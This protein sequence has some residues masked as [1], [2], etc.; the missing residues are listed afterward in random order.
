MKTHLTYDVVFE[1]DNA[2]NRKGWHETFEYCK[3]YIESNNGTNN[4]YFA[5]YK[6]GTVSI[7]CNETEEEVYTYGIKSEKNRVQTLQQLKH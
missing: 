2:S 1:D 3:N 7:Y 5:D 6:G 4:S